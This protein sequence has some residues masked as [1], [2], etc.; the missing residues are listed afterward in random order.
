MENHKILYLEFLEF[1]K[2][3]INIHIDFQAIVLTYF[4]HSKV[5]SWDGFSPNRHIWFVVV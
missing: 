4:Y 5:N 3:L 1:Y 2:S